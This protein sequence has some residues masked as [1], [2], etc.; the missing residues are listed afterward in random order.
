MY[1]TG[2]H[3]HRIPYP[4]VQ[5]PKQAILGLL[6]HNSVHI[7]EYKTYRHCRLINGNA[8]K[9]ENTDTQVANTRVVFELMHGTKVLFNV[10]LLEILIC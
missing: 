7:L 3:V 4:Y 9:M 5:I 6:V 1:G 10:A 8:R 2:R